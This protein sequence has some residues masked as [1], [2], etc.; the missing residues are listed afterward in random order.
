MVSRDTL[1]GCTT[2]CPLG[3]LMSRTLGP[4]YN[5]QMFPNLSYSRPGQQCSP[6]R[7]QCFPSVVTLSAK[8]CQGTK[9]LLR[10]W[11]TLWGRS[12]ISGRVFVWAEPFLIAGS[13]R[14]NTFPSLLCNCIPL[15]LGAGQWELNRSDLIMWEGCNDAW[16]SEW[17]VRLR[18]FCASSP[19]V[20]LSVLPWEILGKVG[21]EDW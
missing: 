6:H 7:S 3:R 17:K 19:S 5:V 18:Q 15:W 11:R 4:W 8:S 1:Q 20:L 16:C 21:C 13:C 12:N 10:V 2:Q 9:E 14:K